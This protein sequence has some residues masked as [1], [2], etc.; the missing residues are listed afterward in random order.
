MTV[1]F[2]IVSLPLFCAICRET[3]AVI[4]YLTCLAGKL[5]EARHL[6][7][8][9]PTRCRLEAHLILAS[10]LE[11]DKTWVLFGLPD[12]TSDEGSICAAMQR[13]PVPGTS[14]E[15]VHRHRAGQHDALVALVEA[16]LV[17]AF[18]DIVDFNVSGASP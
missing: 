7:A 15:L 5:P 12:S 9:N 10:H 6:Y 17:S 13:L 2:Q 3:L 16:R 8:S 11:S 18:S 14:G 4:V 1:K